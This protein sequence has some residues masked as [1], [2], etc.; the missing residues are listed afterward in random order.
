MQF[1]SLPNGRKVIWV[2]GKDKDNDLQIALAEGGGHIAALRLPGLGES[3]N[4]YWQPPW[5]S[6]EPSAVTQTI[7]DQE[8]GGAPEGRLLASILG[9][10]LALDIYGAPSKEETA[11]G[12][13]T[14]GRVGVSPWTWSSSDDGSLVGSCDDPF[15]QLQF[16]RRVQVT[17]HCAMIEE[18]LRNLCAWDRPVCWQ[19]H[20]SFGAPFCEDGFWARANCDMGTTHPE[21]FG[22]GASLA[23]GTEAHWPMARKKDGSVCDYRDPLADGA[24]ANDFTGFRVCRT[25][26]LGNFVAGNRNLGFAVCYLWPRHFF[27]WLGI[28]DEKHARERNPW[29]KLASVRAYEFG[30][31]PYP[32]SRLRLLRRSLLFDVPTFLMLPASGTLRVRYAICAFPGVVEPGEISYRNG[33]ATLMSGSRELGKVNMPES[34]DS[35]IRE[36]MS[37]A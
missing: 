21:S 32:D 37:Q 3:A 9:H 26:P 34:C 18:S 33:G 16:S 11:A 20:V 8:Y 24:M 19:Q 17:G 30:V 35:S 2:G 14:H 22:D 7:L 15:A 31:S 29:R 5:P 4:P 25:D 28:W 27:P 23:P 13:V 6:L 36:D 12:A 10:S 1:D